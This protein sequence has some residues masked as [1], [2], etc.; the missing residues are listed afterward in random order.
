MDHRKLD[1]RVLLMQRVSGRDA[2]GQP[3]QSWQPA[4]SETPDGKIWA[5]VLYPSGIAVVRADSDTATIKAS[6]RIRLR[7]GIDAG[8]RVIVGAITFNVDSVLP[9]GREYLDLVCTGEQV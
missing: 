6:I 7:A 2:A 1:K 5:S 8:M 3:S 9:V 4:V